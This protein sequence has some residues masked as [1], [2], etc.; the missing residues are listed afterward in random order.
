M[1]A[2]RG[3]RAGAA[4]PLA[5]AAAALAA[6]GALA[7]CGG[8]PVKMGAAALVGDDRISTGT[9][10]GVVRSA[11]RQFRTDPAAN[12]IRARLASEQ[13]TGDEGQSDQ[14]RTLGFLIRFRIADEAAKRNGISVADGQID[15]ELSGLAQVGGARSYAVANGLPASRVRDLGRYFAISGAL[16]DRNGADGAATSPAT[17]NAFARVDALYRQTAA[18]MHIKVNPRYGAFDA[19]RSAMQPV[20]YKLS[21]TESGIR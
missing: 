3:G 9:L 5:L 14:Q 21:A 10:N 18:A 12:E 17:Q 16:L 8:D 11:Q 6:A 13:R 19:N 1:K 4:R 2:A 15:R 20:R 7:G